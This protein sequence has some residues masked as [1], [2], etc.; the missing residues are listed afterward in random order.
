MEQKVS[1]RFIILKRSVILDKRLTPTER[2]VY[3]RI[4]MFDEFFE[5]SESTAEMIGVKADTVK[6]SKAKLEKLGYIRCIRNTGRGKVYIPLYD[7]Y[8]TSTDML[9]RRAQICTSDV[10]KYTPIVKKENRNNLDTKVSK[11]G[12]HDDERKEYGSQEINDMLRLWQDA[13]LP[14]ITSRVQSSRRTIWNMLRN[15]SIGAERLK[16]GIEIASEAY[17]EPYA[18]TVINFEDLNRK[19]TALEAWKQKQVVLAGQPKRQP[20][21]GYSPTYNGEIT[22]ERR[23]YDARP[24][25]L[26]YEQSDDV[27]SDEFLE[28]CR[29]NIHKKLTN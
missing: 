19:L 20:A 7:D 23:S 21:S 28:Q 12:S 3:A 22:Y 11:A 10:H 2:N 29:K 25:V 16:R 1:Q 26:S 8:Q 6:K 24:D 5:S 27:V 18:P 17:G 9:D 13:G 14:T 4:C 15:K